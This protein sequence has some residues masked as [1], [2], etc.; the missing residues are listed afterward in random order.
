MEGQ[1]VEQAAV[2]TSEPKPSGGDDAKDHDFRSN[3]PPLWARLVFGAVVLG[4]FYGLVAMAFFLADDDGHRADAALKL[5]SALGPLLGAAIGAMASYFFSEQERQA[6]T[7]RNRRLE[8][9]LGESN[10]A[11][12][13]AEAGTAVA[14]AMLSPDQRVEMLNVRDLALRARISKANDPA[15]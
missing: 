14:M 4:G 7:A 5:A 13:S 1:S 8:G 15:R 2:S 10:E 3:A 11:Q 6:S 9:Q 12:R